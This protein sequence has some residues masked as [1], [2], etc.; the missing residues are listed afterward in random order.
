[1]VRDFDFL[2]AKRTPRPVPARPQIHSHAGIMKRTQQATPRVTKPTQSID[3][4]LP[5]AKVV[6]R[7]ETFSSHSSLI[8]Y[9]PIRVPARSAG[10]KNTASYSQSSPSL[11]DSSHKSLPAH[12]QAPTPKVSIFQKLLGRNK[13]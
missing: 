13:T 7:Q 8:N 4:L 11:T 12:Q 1:M 10:N 2:P 9:H 5:R 6:S 3:G